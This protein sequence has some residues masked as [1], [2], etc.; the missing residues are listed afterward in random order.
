ME[1][2]TSVNNPQVKAAANLKNKKFRT[3]TGRFVAEGLRAVREA[4]AYGQVES[5]FVTDDEAER[6]GDWLDKA[7]SRGARLYRVDGKVMARLS[8]TKTPQGVLAV[9]AMPRAGLADL[10]PDPADPDAPVVILDRIQDPGNL[11]TII[12]TADAAGVQAVLLLEGCVDAYSPKVVRATM[13]SLFHLPLVQHLAAEE[14]LSWCARQG[15]RTVATCLEGASDLYRAELAGKQAF[16][17]G[18]EAN[19]VAPAL[20]QAAA[21]RVFIPM[22]GKAESMNVAMAAGIILFEALRRR[23]YGRL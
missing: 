17:L 4:I 14:V 21:E 20:Q 9:A 3:E 16:I 7:A 15:F 18:N 13:G 8:D 6:L 1:S 22:P 5:L 12:R 11:G 23:R 10:R 2:I 19:G